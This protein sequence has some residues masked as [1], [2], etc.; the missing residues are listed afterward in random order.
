MLRKRVYIYIYIRPAYGQISGLRK[1][2]RA[3]HV[4]VMGIFDSDLG[5]KVSPPLFFPYLCVVKDGGYRFVNSR[6]TGLSML[7]SR[8]RRFFS[9]VDGGE[10]ERREGRRGAM[11]E[12]D[13]KIGGG[14]E[15]R[16]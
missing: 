3:I 15:E 9:F 11:F 12:E 4:N 1:E 10:G 5:T 7:I 8:R 16:T 2:T 14:E 6:N 13:E